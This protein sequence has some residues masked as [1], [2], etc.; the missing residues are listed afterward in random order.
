MTGET[1][2]SCWC[3]D[4]GRT[5]DEMYQCPAGDAGEDCLAHDY[6][7]TGGALPFRGHGR[8]PLPSV[9]DFANAVDAAQTAR[10][11]RQ[12][13]SSLDE[14]RVTLTIQ[15]TPMF[16][17][18]GQAI[19]SLGR[20]FTHILDAWHSQDPRQRRIL[21]KERDRLARDERNARWPAA[22]RTKTAYH[23]RRR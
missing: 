6:L 10:T 3:A 17:Q 1:A 21:L 2:P 18:I 8:Y 14:L 19:R 15:L 4:P 5:D 23:Q 20:G 11:E 13:T 9:S 16:D 22:T 7:A 12:V